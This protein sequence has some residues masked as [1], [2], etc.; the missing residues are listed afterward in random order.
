MFTALYCTLTQIPKLKHSPSAA[1]LDLPFRV[2]RTCA[3]L[4]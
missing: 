3:L 1:L 2:V 4:R